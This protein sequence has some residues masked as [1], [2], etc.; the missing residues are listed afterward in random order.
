MSHNSASVLTA[1]N[2]RSISLRWHLILRLET[3]DVRALLTVE[4]QWE[5]IHLVI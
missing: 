3:V 1:V 5:A 4:Y 2:L